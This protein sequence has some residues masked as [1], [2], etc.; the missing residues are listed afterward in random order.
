MFKKIII[1]NLLV[2]VI[3]TCLNARVI[4]GRGTIQALKSVPITVPY[5]K[6]IPTLKIESLADEGSLIKQ[7]AVVAEF[8]TTEIEH[9][10]QRALDSL[11]NQKA[12]NEKAE[13]SAQTNIKQA[14][15]DVENEIKNVRKAEIFASKR[16]S[17]YSRRQQQSAQL[18]IA[19]ASAELVAQQRTLKQSRKNLK[20]TRHFSNVLYER[21]RNYV[22]RLKAVLKDYRIIRAPRTGVV[23]YKSVYSGGKRGKPRPGRALS[24]GTTFIEIIDPKSFFAD[25]YFSEPHYVYVKKR[26]PVRIE[27]LSDRKRRLEGRVIERDHFIID[28]GDVLLNWSIPDWDRKVFRAKISFD[29]Y[30]HWLKPNMN[31]EVAIQ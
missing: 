22:N 13:L 24:R 19:I 3:T 28:K 31:V 5:I 6:N 11:E 15:L 9:R 26:M 21:Q 7:G 14:Q 16:R 12:S 25:V 2:V 29:S 27:M 23:V 10:L 8:D 17:G 20:A 30:P 4:V 18:D 1:A